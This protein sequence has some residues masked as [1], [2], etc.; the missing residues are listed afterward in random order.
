VSYRHHCGTN[1]HRPPATRRPSAT[2][3][4]SPIPSAGPPGLPPAKWSAPF[5]N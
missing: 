4:R 5:R 2:R 3:L 1:D